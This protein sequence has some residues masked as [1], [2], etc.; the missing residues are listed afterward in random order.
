MMLILVGCSNETE[1]QE[2]PKNNNSNVPK[3]EIEDED[4]G[5]LTL[6]VSKADEE[7]GLSIDNHNIYKELN[8]IVEQNPK[9]GA[10]NDFSL[11]IVD[12]MRDETDNTKLLFLGINRLPEAI[13]NVSFEYT[14]GNEDD[15]FVW[16]NEEVTLTEEQTGVLQVDSAIPIALPLTDE[17]ET[18][19]KTIDEEN[20]MVEIS[21]FKYEKATE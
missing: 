10:A 8:Q 1:E 5:N 6:Q 3:D 16:E 15:E 19:L 7:A 18:L 2:V 11:F 17:Q 9:V 14:L 20:Q 12:T 4:K 13:K 21:N